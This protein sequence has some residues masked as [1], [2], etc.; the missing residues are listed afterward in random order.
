M[1]YP[2][3]L[4]SDLLYEERNVAP[5]VGLLQKVLAPDGLCLLTDQD[6]KP[7]PL[8]RQMLVGSG[9]RFTTELMRA[10]QPGLRVKGTLYR[11]RKGADQ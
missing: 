11:I 9:F 1:Q 7:A 2:L 4:A 8:L 5:V 3:I 10:G 6:R